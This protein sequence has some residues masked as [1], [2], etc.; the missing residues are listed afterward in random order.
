M[1]DEGATSAVDAYHDKVQQAKRDEET[2]RDQAVL[3]VVGGALT[4]SFQLVAS[5]LEHGSLVYVPWLAAAWI[6]WTLALIG[7]LVSYALSISAHQHIL[8]QL[9]KGN[10]DPSTFTSDAGNWV[11][12]ANNLVMIG[13]VVGFFLFGI[14]ALR[15]LVVERPVNLT[16]SKE[17]AHAQ[18]KEKSKDEG[19][20]EGR[21]PADVPP[22]TIREEARSGGSARPAARVPA[23]QEVGDEEMNNDRDVLKKSA[24]PPPPPPSWQVPQQQQ[25]KAPPPP[26]PKKP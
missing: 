7:A 26:P 22:I 9:G 3:L 18:S 2:K 5:L 25:P 16:T 6:V 23:P 8:L 1:Y 19:E 20:E 14:F 13:A 12:R 15:N 17:T 24:P 11:P 21:K 10:Y 4:L